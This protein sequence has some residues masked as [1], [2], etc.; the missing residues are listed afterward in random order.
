MIHA[1][2]V[3]LIQAGIPKEKGIWA[4]L[5]S[6]DGAFTL[7]LA[8]LADPYTTIFSIDKDEERLRTQE[9]LFAK[10]FPKADVHFFNKDFTQPL[11]VPLL[12]GI[13]MANSLHFIKEKVPF[14]RSL[15]SYLKPDGRLLIVEYNVDQGNMWVPY[16]FSYTTFQELAIQAKFFNTQLLATVPSQFLHEMYAAVAFSSIVN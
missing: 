7:A 9:K 4:D 1:D 11:D 10:M 15:H 14:L 16:P 3:S 13:I 5:G 2:H 12:D 6:G 8:E